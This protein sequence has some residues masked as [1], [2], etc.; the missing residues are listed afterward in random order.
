MSRD[1]CSACRPF[2]SK[3]TRLFFVFF[4]FC[5]SFLDFIFEDTWSLFCLPTVLNCFFVHAQGRLGATAL[6]CFRYFWTPQHALTPYKAHFTIEPG[7]AVN[8]GAFPIGPRVRRTHTSRTKAKRS[9]IRVGLG[10]CCSGAADAGAFANDL[11]PY[12][13]HFRTH[14]FC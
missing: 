4:Y 1:A 6:L 10:H 5:V 9:R 14:R 2:V 3:V 13:A 11:L 8:Q 12:R 7:C